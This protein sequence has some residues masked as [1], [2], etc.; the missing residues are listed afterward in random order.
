MTKKLRNY[1]NGQL[2]LPTTKDYVTVVNP[3]DENQLT[4]LPL[5]NTE[6]VD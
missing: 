5:S 2:F 3:A 6:D 4:T 1:V